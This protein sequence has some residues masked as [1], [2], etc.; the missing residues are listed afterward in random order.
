MPQKEEKTYLSPD[1]IADEI[2]ISSQTILRWLKKGDLVGYKFDRAWRVKREDLDEFMES[3][4][5]V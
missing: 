1:E 3:R 4:R 2:S 5:N